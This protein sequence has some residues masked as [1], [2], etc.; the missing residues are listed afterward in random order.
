MNQNKYDLKL[1]NQLNIQLKTQYL[2]LKF[3]IE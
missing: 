2:N 1:K 3:F